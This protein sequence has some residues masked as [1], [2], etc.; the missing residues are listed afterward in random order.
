[1]SDIKKTTY[2]FNSRSDGLALSVLRF[3]PENPTEI[4]GIVQLVH[5]MNEYK[6]RYIPFM[7]FLAG[8]GY[9]CVIHDH[10]GHGHSVEKKEDLGYWYKGGYEAL[11]ED[12]HDITLDIKTYA[13]NLTGKTDLQFILLGHS[14][15]SMAVRC[16]LQRY[17]DELSKLI[18][19]GCPSKQ[20]GMKSGL[21]LIKIVKAFKGERHVSMFI[22]GLVM[23]NYEKKFAKEGLPHSWV[24]SNPEEVKKYGNDPYC[25]YVFT[26]NGFENLVKLTM[27]TYKKSGY[28][29]N[30]PSLPIRFFSGADDPCAVSEKAF[31]A[32]VDLIKKQGYTDA[33]GKLYEGMRH[34][35]LNEKNKDMVYKD[36]LEFIKDTP[37]A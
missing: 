32:A 34:E 29:M 13:R 17:D 23:G 22:A 14:M 8:Q 2:S 7:E 15:G 33:E 10:R 28:V 20:P 25:N 37:N 11:I 4:K 35:I 21:A 3:E 27:E 19:V 24:N 26:L 31:N 16:Y 9:L 1:M 36:I 12:I 18:V 30:N 6:E 5:G